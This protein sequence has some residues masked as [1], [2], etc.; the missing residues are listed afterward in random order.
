MSRID[1]EDGCGGVE[2]GNRILK[3][4]E[5]G[6][7]LISN[8]ISNPMVVVYPC[9][10]YGVEVGLELSHGRDWYDLIHI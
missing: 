1:M 10:G 8:L 6:A 7:R 4:A 9:M 5:V 2:E 3:S